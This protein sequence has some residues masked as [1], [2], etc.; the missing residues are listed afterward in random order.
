MAVAR[1]IRLLGAVGILMVLVLIFRLSKDSTPFVSDGGK[2]V[3]GM[4]HD[5]LLDRMY[6]HSF[7]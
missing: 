1:P 4:K 2:L 7:G 6:F 5:P 3:N